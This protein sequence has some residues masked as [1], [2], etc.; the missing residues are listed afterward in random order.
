MRS[1]SFI[2]NSLVAG[3]ACA[4]TMGPGLAFAQTPES[5]TMTVT[6][7]PRPELDALG[8]RQGGFLLFP[9][10][11]VTTAYNDN[12]FATESNTL[13]DV[14]FTVSPGLRV[15]S[16]WNQHF[17][18]F[19]GSGD[20]VRYADQTAEDHEDFSLGANGRLDIRRDTNATAGLFYRAESEERGSPD[21]VNGRTPTDYTVAGIDT[22]FFQRWNR[23][24]AQADFGFQQYDFD[25]VATSAGTII[26]NDDRDRDEY[27]FSLRGGYEIVPEYEAYL[28]GIYSAVNY[29]SAVDD[30]GVN[31]DNDG[32]EVRVG[33]RVDLSALVFGDVYVGYITRDYDDAS[34]ESADAV[35]AGADLT[36][37]ATTLTTVKGGINREVSETTLA[38]ASGRL[39]TAFRSSVDH[40]LLRNLILSGRFGLSRDEYEGTSREDDYIRAGIGGKYMLNR[41]FHLTLQYDYINRTS[42]AANADYDRNLVFLRLRAQM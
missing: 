5:R 38:N 35:S 37:N 21:D 20:I 30:N 26:N 19:Q 7:R 40:E 36:W 23:V 13:D 28:Q 4:C 33:A 15:Q 9:S 11:D 42:S 14:I 24:S 29:D 2:R 34:L 32:F 1:L 8:I 27:R 25:D 17:L 16:D 18:Q 12:I 10:I 39:S 31:R 6:E 3:A 41:N 22:G